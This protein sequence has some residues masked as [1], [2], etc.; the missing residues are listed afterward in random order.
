MLPLETDQVLRCGCDSHIAGRGENATKNIER[1][2]LMRDDRSQVLVCSDAQKR[3][4]AFV[5][6]SHQRPMRSK[7]KKAEAIRHRCNICVMIQ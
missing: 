1:G 2:A 4:L 5:G 3:Y 7:G 6:W